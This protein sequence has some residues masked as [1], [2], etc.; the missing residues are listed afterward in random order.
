MKKIG[1]LGS[2]GS[3]GTQALEL[4]H[5][6][7]KFNVSYLSAHSNFKLLAEQAVEFCVESICISDSQYLE[8]LKNELKGHNIEILCG[9]KG[10]DELSNRDSIDLMLNA[11]VGYSGM[12]PTY[13][14]VK[15]G[16]DIALANKESLVAGG[17]LIINELKKS[18]SKLFPVDSE[19]S[20]I[21]QC[22]VGEKNSEIKKLILTGSGGPFR[23]LDIEQFPSIKKE[24]ALKH[25]NWEMGSKITIDSATMMNKGFEVIEAF[26]LFN[27]PFEKIE[28]VI[29]PQSIIHSMIE[30]IDGSIKAQLGTPNMTIPI[31]YAI[32]YPNRTYNN[33]YNFNFYD[34]KNLSFH[35]PDFNKFKCIKLAYESLKL[36]KSYSIVLNVA[37]DL[38][39]YA[40]L[41][42]KISFVDI[43]NYIEETL[44]KHI[45][46]SVKNIESIFDVINKTTLDINERIYK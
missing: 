23:K 41:K 40:F 36:G 31:N 10:I 1:I 27:L 4:I 11:L 17:E 21:W 37:N 2:T 18:E 35:K 20:A 16:T 46:Q 15:C 28:I 42:N 13:N 43:P 22:M 25:P 5:N 9:E 26:W 33:K 24:D 19:H 34:S 29:H 14:A 7:D 45:P 3:I 39:V 6:N 30:F 38:C 8:P 44:D 32:N 12:L